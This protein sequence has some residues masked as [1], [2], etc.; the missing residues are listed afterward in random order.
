MTQPGEPAD[1]NP[2]D[3]RFPTQKP[4]ATEIE[5]RAAEWPRDTEVVRALFREYAASL[6]IDLGF[7]DFEMELATLPGK[8]APPAG[9]LLLAWRGGEAV[10]CVALRPLDGSACEMKRLYVRPGLRGERLGGRLTAS[11]CQ[12]ARV[13]AYARICLDTLPTMTAAIRLYQSLGFRPTAPYVFNPIPGAMFL[14]LA[15]RPDAHDERA[16][17]AT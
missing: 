1:C 12:E 4:M 5:I 3:Y 15:L 2:F 9:Q 6:G 8:Y 16:G 14:A 11:I 13:A 17:R 7:Q 10:G